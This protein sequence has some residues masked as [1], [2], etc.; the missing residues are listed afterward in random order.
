[1]APAST[2]PSLPRDAEALA[3]AIR[4][5]HRE[6]GYLRLELPGELCVEPRAG[7]I[8]AGLRQVAGVW[9]V[10]LYRAD[11][12]LA[13]RHDA[14]T[15]SVHQVASQLRALLDELPREAA[16]GV[17]PPPAPML[18]HDTLR[19]AGERLGAQAARTAAQWRAVLQR[20]RTPTGPMSELQ[21][22]LQPVLASALTEKAIIGFFN[23]LLAFY[24][25]KVHWDLI[26]RR[27]LKEPVHHANAWLAVFYLVFLLVRF[28]KLNK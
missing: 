13:I 5:R 10:T 27:W 8:E 9:R 25:I 1:M 18:R 12:K 28:R 17:P 7:A 26:T 24:L 3:R 23:D 6:A 4:V 11:R 21:A 22:R 20:L 14:H 16:P 2:G 19:Q 15:C